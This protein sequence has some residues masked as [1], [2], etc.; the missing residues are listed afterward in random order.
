MKVDI[1]KLSSLKAVAAKPVLWSTN[2]YT[3]PCGAIVASGYAKK[4]GF[5]HEEWNND[6]ARIWKG[7]RVFHTETKTRLDAYAQRGNLALLM[8]SMRGD[9]Q[10]AMGI[11]CGVWANSDIDMQRIA[12]G[13]NFAGET[14][15]LWALPR[16]QKIFKNRASLERT[17]QESMAWIRWRCPTDLYHW[18]EEPI[19]IPPYSVNPER[20]VLAKMH[21][22]YQ[23]IRPEHALKIASHA[24]PKGH[25]IMD[26][27]IEGDF[28]DN[29]LSRPL[30]RQPGSTKEHRR[31]SYGAPAAQEPYLRYLNE[32]VIKVDPKHADLEARF[33]AYLGS[34]GVCDILPNQDRIDLRFDHP[35]KGPVIAELKPAEPGETKYAIRFAI[36]QVLEYRHAL[37][38][39]AMPMIILGAKP[40][41]SERDF[42]GSLGIALAWPDRKSFKLDWPSRRLFPVKSD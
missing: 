26:W 34:I 36:G 31:A 10:Y 15:R 33:H 12:A 1:N 40:S 38:S 21:S 42:V 9:Q 8:T 5:G 32:R 41:D 24:L 37:H 3:G 22:S 4:N 17:W 23:G 11:A 35:E 2:N 7:Q 19:Q 18:F 25:P 13:L 20:M 16:I 39:K 14:E 28:D 30:R 29:L 27:L 6:P